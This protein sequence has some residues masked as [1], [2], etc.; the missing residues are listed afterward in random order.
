MSGASAS[1][2]HIAHPH[3]SNKLPSNNKHN[4][5]Y[6]QISHHHHIINTTNTGSNKPHI[7]HLRPIAAT[8]SIKSRIEG[9]RTVTL[10]FKLIHALFSALS[11]RS[12]KLTIVA[13]FITL[14]I[15][16]TN[17]ITFNL[18][19]NIIIMFHLSPSNHITVT[20]TLSWKL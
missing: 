18:Q 19:F 11:L 7:G 1:A 9:V 13:T 2:A 4:P 5:I 3:R 14:I 8:F 20:T 12:I 6:H 17:T 16:I 10:A 15:W